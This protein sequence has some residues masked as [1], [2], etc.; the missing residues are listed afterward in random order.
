MNLN[1]DYLIKELTIKK[2]YNNTDNDTFIIEN[3]NKDSEIY[4]E[5]IEDRESN[6]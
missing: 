3:I 2:R 1:K 5:L 4:K 6:K